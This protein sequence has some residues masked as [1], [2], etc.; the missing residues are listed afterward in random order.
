MALDPAA[1]DIEVEQ[2]IAQRTPE[3][4]PALG[5]VD[6]GAGEDATGPA[7]GGQL[8]AEGREVRL[9]R[10][11]EGETRAFGE[12]PTAF[13]HRGQHVHGHLARKMVV[14]RARAQELLRR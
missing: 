1:V 7:H 10:L 8:D 12:K 3:M 6:A 14:A 5:E 13:E 2:R 11:R 4:G 9:A